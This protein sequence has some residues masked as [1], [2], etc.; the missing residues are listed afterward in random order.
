[1]KMR[2]EDRG[3]L[4]EPTFH[5]CNKKEKII[6][7]KLN[8]VEKENHHTYLINIKHIKL[9]T[10]KQ[11]VFLYIYLDGGERVRRIIMCLLQLLIDTLICFVVN[12]IGWGRYY[13]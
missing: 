6:K 2:L 11:D 5:Y 10:M 13:I 1:M 7:E 12:C 9:L 4:P 3:V 8:I